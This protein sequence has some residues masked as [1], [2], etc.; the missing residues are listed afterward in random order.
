LHPSNRD[1]LSLIAP[2][3][4]CAASRGRRPNRRGHKAHWV[5]G[6]SRTSC[7]LPLQQLRHSAR[8]ASSDEG[9]GWSSCVARGRG[10]VAS[11]GL[12]SNMCL[13]SREAAERGLSRVDWASRGWGVANA[14]RAA[15]TVSHRAVRG[16]FQDARGHVEAVGQGRTPGSQKATGPRRPGGS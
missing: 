10:E 1:T 6:H 4:E 13:S 11:L 2:T 3:T 12:S 15:F 5:E 8:M 14:A 16:S 7:A 9:T